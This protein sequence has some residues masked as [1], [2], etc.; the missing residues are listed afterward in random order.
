MK[1]VVTGLIEPSKASKYL[2]KGL[3]G[4]IGFQAHVLG[5]LGFQ[6][7][8]GHVLDSLDRELAGGPSLTVQEPLRLRKFANI[9]LICC[10]QKASTSSNVRSSDGRSES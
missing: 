9:G 7:D 6:R 1:L 10:S 5:A 2:C 3:V 4:E 8:Q